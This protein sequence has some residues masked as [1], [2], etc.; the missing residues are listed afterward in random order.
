MNMA[1][2]AN[3]PDE[4]QGQRTLVTFQ[5]HCQTYALPIE[6]VEQIVETVTVTPIPQAN[7][8][9]Q[10]VIN[11]RGKA[12]PAVNLRRYFGLP[13]ADTSLDA[14]II[15]ARA[16]AWR[17]GLVVDQVLDVVSLPANEVVHPSEVLPEGLGSALFLR[18]LVQSQGGMVL[19]LDPDQLFLADQVHGLALPAAI[20]EALAAR[21][22]T[23]AEAAPPGGDPPDIG[24]AAPE[25]AV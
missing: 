10:G 7:R 25:V 11:V 5:L 18:G 20:E 6:P 24:A 23:S 19:V 12:V 9:V 17:V 8:L 13:E 21:P 3:D 16:G 14:H 4:E 22:E 15:L 1:W 2:T